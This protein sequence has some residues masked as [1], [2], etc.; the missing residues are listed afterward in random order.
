MQ[1]VLIFALLL[2]IGIPVF[3]DEVPIAFVGATVYPVTG[4]PIEDGIVVVHQGTI[5]DVGTREAV[6]IPDDADV[7]DVSDKGII[8]GM[9]DTHSH[10]GRGDGGDR[11]APTHP[12]V[13]ILDAI[14]AQHQ[15]F[16]RAR[17]GGITTVNIMPGSGHLLSGQT[18]YLKTRRART[19]YDMLLCDDV[20]TDICGGIKMANGT[21][22]IGQAPFPQ[23][24]SRSAAI[25]RQ[26]YLNA[27]EY[28]E[29]L[30][31]ANGDPE[32]M[33]SRN[34]Q[35]EALVEV[36]EGKRIVHHHTHRHDDIMTVLRLANEFGFKVVLHHVSEGWK[37]ADEIAEANI[38]ASIILV[39]SPGGKLE[40]VNL[41]YENGRDLEKAGVDVAF[42]TDDP[43]TDSRLFLRQAAI[44]V[45]TG[46]SKEKALE[47]LTLAGARML[48]MED[49]I[50]SLE[51]GKDADFVILSGDPFSVY[52]YVEQTWVDGVKV[53]DRSDPEDYKYAVGGYGVYP[54]VFHHHYEIGG[55]R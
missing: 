45:R 29:K 26:L 4:D 43:I 11:S 44:G 1:K 42:H 39:D 36:L 17:A 40:A 33:P 7:I 2:K 14:D 22:P 9:I 32:K 53:Y 35:M 49:N 6:S 47:G 21:N 37:V 10:I 27:Q 55:E 19:I 50:G 12:E 48:G 24:R 38:P 54:G 25:V 13:R 46:M 20:N 16:M 30:E 28:R 31:A 52:T 5:L 51:E 18:V 23:T 34:L 15:S 41:I 8:P 3:G